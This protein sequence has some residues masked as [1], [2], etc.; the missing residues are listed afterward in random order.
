M[1]GGL[2]N[3]VGPE[4]TAE[5]SIALLSKEKRLPENTGGLASALRPIRS[6]LF[7]EVDDPSQ[8]LAASSEEALEH[9][10]IECAV[11][12]VLLH[13]RERAI[14]EPSKLAIAE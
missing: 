4:G 1:P 2:Q 6:S 9:A 5:G 7:D 13:A 14:E 8:V 3:W 10:V 11:A 12:A